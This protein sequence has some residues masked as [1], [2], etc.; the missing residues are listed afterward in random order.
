MNE[1]PSF[2]GPRRTLALALTATLVACADEETVAV[3][4]PEPA[5]MAP[6]PPASVEAVPAP[7]VAGSGV[8]IHA[9]ANPAFCVDAAGDRPQKHT[10]VQLYACHGRENQ[11]WNFTPGANG[12]ATITG[13]AGLCLDIHGTLPKEG[14]TAQ[15]YPCHDAGNQQFSLDPEGH[16][17]E[18]A[19][20]KCL[21]VERA[22]N[23]A[24]IF[25]AP[26]DPGNPG[27]VW[28]VADR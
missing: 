27:Q 3:R 8:M 17:R 7:A 24:P 22:A 20:G 12:A 16:L 15:L 14:A 9:V 26:C 21:T 25:V 23:R 4:H 18:V 19:T 13:V 28:S 10:P 5:D 1:L 2:R 11:R 6:Q